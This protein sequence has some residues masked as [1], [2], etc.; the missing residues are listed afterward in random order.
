M[1][2]LVRLL[3]YWGW[4]PRP[5]REDPRLY[6]DAHSQ[7]SSRWIT[8][9]EMDALRDEVLSHKYLRTR[10]DEAEVEARYKE[11]RRSR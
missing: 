4:L 5:H 7:R 8:P 11:R 10:E 2:W 6:R 1:S 3:M 9:E